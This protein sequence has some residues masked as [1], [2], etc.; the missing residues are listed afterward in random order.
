MATE[1][2]ELSYDLVV[3]ERWN[4]PLQ[5]PERDVQA[6]TEDVSPIPIIYRREGVA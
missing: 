1:F 3:S 5:I 6:L 2:Y 4:L